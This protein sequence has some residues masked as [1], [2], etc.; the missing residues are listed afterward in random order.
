MVPP[1]CPGDG[2][3][4]FAANIGAIGA[5]PVATK[6]VPPHRVDKKVE[7]IFLQDPSLFPDSAIS[8]PILM[9]CSSHT[10]ACNALGTTDGA[11]SHC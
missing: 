5:G 8:P 1:K 7:P 9:S 4:P 11:T 2:V 6:A 3:G 10:E